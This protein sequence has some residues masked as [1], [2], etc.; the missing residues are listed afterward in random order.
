MSIR[1]TAFYQFIRL[2]DPAA[3]RAPL[4]EF[5]QGQDLRGT[6]LLA[7]EGINGTIA[8]TAGAIE[9][10]VQALRS[11]SVIQPAFDRMELK[12][13]GAET[14]P[15]Q[16]LK[17][18][19]KREIVTLG[20]SQADPLTA[21]GAYV[22][23]KD[24]NAVLAD[25]EILLIDTRNA[26]EVARGSFPGAINP[27]TER[28]SDFVEFSR[29]NLDPEKHKRI[30]MFCTGGI[31]CEKASAFL[32]SEGFGQ[33][34]HLKGGILNYLESVPAEQSRWHG[35]CFVFDERIAL[36]HTSFTEPE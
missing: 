2:P 13:S 8:G 5:C 22:D 24:W 33:V 18:L 4:R 1:V 7:P 30:A 3:L 35:E 28:F 12:F 21:V 34:L 26:F 10:F 9:A 32:L 15:F 27:H 23:P 17:I 16:R 6:I 25:P 11:G 20:E 29:K 14:P 36:S 19:L 31:R